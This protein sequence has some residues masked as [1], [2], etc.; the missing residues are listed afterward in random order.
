MQLHPDET[1]ETVERLL[2]LI[3]GKSTGNAKF[4]SLGLEINQLNEHS[5]TSTIYSL[6]AELSLEAEGILNQRMTEGTEDGIKKFLESL[7]I[8]EIKEDYIEQI[9]AVVYQDISNTIDRASFKT[10]WVFKFR[11]RE[12]DHSKASSNAEKDNLFIV[13]K[14]SGS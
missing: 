1:M 6:F 4:Q 10:G 5:V 3:Q 12:G 14:L 9:K 11:F 13:I 2:G 8:K 7:N